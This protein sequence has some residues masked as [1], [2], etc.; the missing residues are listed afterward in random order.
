[1]IQ[2]GVE[3]DGIRCIDAHKFQS[4]GFMMQRDGFAF[5]YAELSRGVYF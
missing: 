1:M 2:K 3:E 4:A 5:F